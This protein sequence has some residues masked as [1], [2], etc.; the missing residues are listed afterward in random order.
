MEYYYE[1]TMILRVEQEQK[2]IKQKLDKLE[3]DSAERVD[4]N[5]DLLEK[6]EQELETIQLKIENL[7]DTKKMDEFVLGMLMKVDQEQEKLKQTLNKLKRVES[8]KLNTSGFDFRGMRKTHIHPRKTI[9]NINPYIYYIKKQ[10]QPTQNILIPDSTLTAYH[11]RPDKTQDAINIRNKFLISDISPAKYEWISRQSKYTDSLST[12]DKHILSSY[13]YHG[14]KLV[15]G[16]CR[17]NIDNVGDLLL[18][19]IQTFAE[20]STE[21]PVLAY[22]L[23]DQYDDYSKRITLPPKS[24]LLYVDIDRILS[25]IYNVIVS[26]IVFLSEPR[27]IAT[28]LEQYKQELIRIISNSPKLTKPLVVYR[29]FEHEKHITSAQFVSNDFMSTTIDPNVSFKFASQFKLVYG[30]VY[31]ITIDEHVPCIYMENNTLVHEEFEV[32]V[33]PGMSITLDN[34]I[35]Y[36]IIPSSS[37]ITA[38]LLLSGIKQP[39]DDE[40]TVAIIHASVTRPAPKHRKSKIVWNAVDSVDSVDFRKTHKIK[41][42]SNLKSKPYT[43]KRQHTKVKHRRSKRPVSIDSFDSF[44]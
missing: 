28:L 1:M 29:G 5:Q 20:Q 43:Y 31:E 13:S 7:K 44:D 4:S 8:Y 18:A 23:F 25:P 10:P 27:N 6:V 37:D 26:N 40:T 21:L 41:S 19:D 12:R 36:K 32:L 15:N 2:K 39:S 17:G 11:L 30:G 14:D 3:I 33:P 22:F 24:D 9:K 35:Y 42:K 16:Y 34:T 38:Y